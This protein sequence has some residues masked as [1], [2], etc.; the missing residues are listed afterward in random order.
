MIAYFMMTLDGDGMV[1]FRTD[2]VL[3]SLCG[4]VKYPWPQ[5]VFTRIRWS[6]MCP[7]CMKISGLSREFFHKHAVRPGM[8]IK[9]YVLRV[10][11]KF[12]TNIAVQEWQKRQQGQKF[13]YNPYLVFNRFSRGEAS[14]WELANSQ[15][16]VRR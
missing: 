5:S 9:F 1:H 7:H 4:K 11:N 13:F 6:A 16:K 12:S 3:K 8:P 2:D 15:I 14:E 10:P